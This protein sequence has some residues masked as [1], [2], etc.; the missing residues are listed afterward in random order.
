[1]TK[2]EE[3]VRLHKPL[4]VLIV[5]ESADGMDDV[6]RNHTLKIPCLVSMIMKNVYDHQRLVSYDHKFDKQKCDS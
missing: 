4:P 1:M 2:N 3:A 5:H 6:Q